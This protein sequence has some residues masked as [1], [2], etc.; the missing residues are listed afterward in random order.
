MDGL[1]PDWLE[2]SS[3]SHANP[4]K[5]PWKKTSG[6]DFSHMQMGKLRLG[7]VKGL[8]HPVILGN[9]RVA[10][11]FIKGCLLPMCQANNLATMA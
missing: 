4:Q 3:H 9:A 5:N 7:K 8:S 6:S 10:P 1:S 11:W 2:R